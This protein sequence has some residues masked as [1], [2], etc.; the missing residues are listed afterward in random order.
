MV[1]K[2]TAP[3]VWRNHEGEHGMRKYIR[4]SLLRTRRGSSVK[5]AGTT[6]DSLSVEDVVALVQQAYLHGYIDGQDGWPVTKGLKESLYLFADE[7]RG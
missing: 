1:V 7:L 6:P 2:H 5:D 3:S 4:R